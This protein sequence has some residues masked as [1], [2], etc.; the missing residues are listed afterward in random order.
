[1]NK[2]QIRIEAYEF[3]Y[4]ILISAVDGQGFDVDDP[5]DEDKIRREI[6]QMALELKRRAE[7]MRAR[8]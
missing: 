5:E 6:D 4:S 3:A 1:M 8:G 7:R 2:R